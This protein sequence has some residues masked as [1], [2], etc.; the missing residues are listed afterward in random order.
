MGVYVKCTLLF[1]LK[2]NIL[3]EIQSSLV[4]SR[5]CMNARL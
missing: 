4:D 5:H 1:L 3:N 2:W